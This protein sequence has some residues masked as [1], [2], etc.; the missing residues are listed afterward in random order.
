MKN[1]KLL[2]LLFSFAV[3]GFAAQAQVEYITG[4]ARS[5]NI[6]AATFYV[7]QVKDTRAD[8]GSIGNTY[9]VSTGRFVPIQLAGGPGT[10]IKN[11][12]AENLVLADS[13]QLA[14]NIIIKAFAI[15]EDTA[16]NRRKGIITITIGVEKMLDGQWQECYSGSASTDVTAYLEKNTDLAYAQPIALVLHDFLQVFNTQVLSKA[17]SKQ[18]V[19]V[20]AGIR[21]GHIKPSGT[22]TITWV[23]DRPLQADD[24][25]AVMPRSA[26]KGDV[27]SASASD[28]AVSINSFTDT[29]GRIIV[30]N[31]ATLF[32][33]HLSWIKPNIKDEFILPFEQMRFDLARLYEIRLV[34]YLHSYTFTFS[35]FNDQ[36][37]SIYNDFHNK[38]KDELTN[39]VQDCKYAASGVVSKRNIGVWKTKIA[40]Q[41]QEENYVW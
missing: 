26:K 28:F 19:T 23:A 21:F 11:I 36:F 15:K 14:V 31:A 7:V 6:D 33:K 24:F 16:N 37:N 38:L 34:K 25:M 10:Y 18:T 35:H 30:I 9:S 29:A 27:L 17:I 2:L 4:K 39:M 5:V 32:I 1:A 8:T 20:I 22:D 41:L 13:N 12:L 3:S 40:K